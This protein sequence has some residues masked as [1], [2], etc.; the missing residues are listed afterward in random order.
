MGL[1]QGVFPQNMGDEGLIKDREREAL[2]EAGIVLA[3]G[4]LP[5]AV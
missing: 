1:N 5:K 3:E 4:A 2:A